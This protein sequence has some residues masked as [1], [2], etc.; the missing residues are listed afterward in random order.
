M[1]RTAKRI[2]VLMTV[3]AAI[4]A[5]KLT[6]LDTLLTFEQFKLYQQ[7]LV[8]FVSLNYL[9]S[10]IIYILIYL[11]VTAVSIPGAAVLTL[12]GGFLFGFAGI[13]YVNIGATSGAVSAF[14]FSRYIF[15]S[16]IQ[17]K[18]ED[19]LSGFNSEIE[20]HGNNYMLALRF[21]PLIPFFLVNIFAGISRIPLRTFLWT[22]SVGI[23]P[24]S[25]VY[26]YS[27][28][29]AG[30]LESIA[31][32]ISARILIAFLLLALMS[33]APVFIKKLFKDKLK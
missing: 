31:D 12:A 7:Q 27:G 8:S 13:F 3:A 28:R 14:M 20:K 21:I 30:T 5:V 18:Y 10:V 23:I 16:W 1:N 24:G 25:F 4:A 29:Q 17:N 26:I 22:T 33:L 9:F 15:G 32:I 6:G 19:K 2:I 11:I